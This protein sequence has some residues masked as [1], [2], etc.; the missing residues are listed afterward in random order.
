MSLRITLRDGERMIVN[1]AV[2]RARGRCEIAVENRVSI[3]RGRE[4][5]QPEEATTPAR[6]LYLACMMAYI[7]EAGRERHNAELL[8]LLGDLVRAFE[9]EKARAAC[10]AFAE[11]VARGDYYAALGQCR[12]LIDHEGAALARIAA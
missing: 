4:I 7:D 6:R 3:L 10:V 5:M 2:L 12:R 1:G 11:G 9:N 8:D